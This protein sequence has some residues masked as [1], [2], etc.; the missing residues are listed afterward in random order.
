MSDLLIALFDLGSSAPPF[1]FNGEV[2]MMLR[3][4]DLQLKHLAVADQLVAIRNQFLPR[5]K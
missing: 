1:G 2:P 4:F 5:R 3:A